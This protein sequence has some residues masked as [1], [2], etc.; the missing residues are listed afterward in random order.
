MIMKNTEALVAQIVFKMVDLAEDRKDLAQ[1]IYLKAFR[2]I[3]GFRFESKLS[4]WIARIAYHTCINHLERKKPIVYPGSLLKSGTEIEESSPFFNH[5][6]QGFTNETMTWVSRKELKIILW[7]EVGKLDP[8][9]KT[10]ITL[11]HQEEMSY[12]EIADIT[13]MP[14]GT[15]KNYLFRARRALKDI[16]LEKFKKEDL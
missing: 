7:T 1:E 16:L 3:D 6:I 8:I 11:F 9:H 12:D 4:T 10:L 5:S 13:E 15:V 2:K 14:I